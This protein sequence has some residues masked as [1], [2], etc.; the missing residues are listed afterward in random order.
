MKRFLPL[1]LVATFAAVPAFAQTIELIGRYAWVRTDTDERLEEGM[2]PEG[3]R[4][5]IDNETGWGGAINIYWTRHFS[6]EIGASVVKPDTLITEDG[7]IT[8]VLLNNSLTLLPITAVLQY[9]FSPDGPWSLYIG[10][11]GAWTLIDDLEQGIED[12]EQEDIER[13]EFEDHA[14]FVVNLG[15]NI[16]LTDNIAVNIDSKYVPVRSATKVVFATGEES[17]GSEIDFN[18]LILGLGVSFR[19]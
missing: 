1:A 15:F 19:F 6:T 12:I 4:L 14:G 9:H 7:D 5:E 18:P 17:E 2:A 8:A 13:I 11:G 10:A 3:A 16:K